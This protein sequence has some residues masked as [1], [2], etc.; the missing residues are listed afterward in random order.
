MKKVLVLAVVFAFAVSTSGKKNEIDVLREQGF[1]IFQPC[2][3][4]IVA[5]AKWGKDGLFSQVLPAP[6]IMSHVNTVVS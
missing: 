3:Q 6:Q 5:D 4:A 1:R 2:L